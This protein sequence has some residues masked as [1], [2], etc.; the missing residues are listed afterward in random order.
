MDAFVVNDLER[1]WAPG[2]PVRHALHHS[3]DVDIVAVLEVI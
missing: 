1:A 3:R 2:L